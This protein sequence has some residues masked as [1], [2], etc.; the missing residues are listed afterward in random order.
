MN[1]FTNLDI[2]DLIM[3]EDGK[4]SYYAVAD[5]QLIDWIE[6]LRKAKG[7]ADFIN[8]DNDIYYNFYVEFD[9]GK[10]EIKLVGIANNTELDDYENYECELTSKE[11]EFIMW[12][13][14]YEMSKATH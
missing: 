2:C 4:G 5:D 8:Y 13:I 10:K 7:Y 12:L 9:F 1:R 6:T 3:D 14:I 11:K